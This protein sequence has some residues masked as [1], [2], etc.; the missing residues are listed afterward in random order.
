MPFFAWSDTSKKASRTKDDFSR[1][2]PKKA[3][4][5]EIDYQIKMTRGQV[6]FVKREMQF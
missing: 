4:M 6:F 1:Q 3:R 2:N 5:K